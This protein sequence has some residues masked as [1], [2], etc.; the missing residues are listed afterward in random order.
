MVHAMPVAYTSIAAA[1]LFHVGHRQMPGAR[2]IS[3][4][5][6]LLPLTPLSFGHGKPRLPARPRSGSTQYLSYAKRKTVF[7]SDFILAAKPTMTSHRIFLES[8]KGGK[9]H[10]MANAQPPSLLQAAGDM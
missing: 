9:K 5:H 6:H 8:L 7:Q 4:T 2:S 1:G 10:D 3:T